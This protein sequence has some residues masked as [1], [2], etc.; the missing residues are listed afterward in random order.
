[1]IIR[2]RFV[3]GI[4][5]LSMARP[6]P[7]RQASASLPGLRAPRLT[8]TGG[9]MML[10]AQAPPSRVGGTVVIPG[11]PRASNSMTVG[12]SAR[13]DHRAG[14]GDGQVWQGQGTVASAA[15]GRRVS[16]RRPPD[17]TGPLQ[18]VP[19]GRLGPL[20]A[21]RPGSLWRLSNVHDLPGCMRVGRPRRVDC[22][23]WPGARATRERMPV[24]RAGRRRPTDV[25]FCR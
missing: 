22:D 20:C 17:E 8:G 19:P 14:H 18:T 11:S 2:W 9:G 4:W 10:A 12:G 6:A 5:P 7:D 13:P 24:P 21:V 3:G 15:A 23:S 25:R 16:Y 1:L